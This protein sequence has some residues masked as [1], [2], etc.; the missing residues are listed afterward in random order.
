MLSEVK[1]KY[2]EPTEWPT[3][4]PIF[5]AYLTVGASMWKWVHHYNQEIKTFTVAAAA[6]AVNWVDLVCWCLSTVT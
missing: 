6:A 5:Y 2:V 3:K 4:L 1:D